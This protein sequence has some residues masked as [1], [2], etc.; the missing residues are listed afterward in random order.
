LLDR[1]YGV[2][3]IPAPKLKQYFKTRYQYNIEFYKHFEVLKR[4]HVIPEDSLLE[5]T[6]EQIRTDL[7]GVVQKIKI[8]GGLSFSPE[9]EKK[10]EKQAELQ[11]SYKRKHQNLSLE[12]FNLTEEKIRADFDF[13]FKRYGFE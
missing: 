10:L 1:C 6:H 13:V 11:S 2:D 3:N 4:D 5:I 12:Q 8:F 7:W 9:L